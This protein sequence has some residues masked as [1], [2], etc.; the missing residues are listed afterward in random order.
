LIVDAASRAAMVVELLAEAYP[1]A[2]C[3][4]DHGSPWQ[5]LVATVLSAQCTDVRVNRV[6]PELFARWPGPAEM[7]AAS[8][9][10]LESVIRSTGMFRRKAASL[11]NAARLVVDRH[12]GEVPSTMDAL[13][14][15]PGVGRK[16]AKV[17]LGEGFGIA[18]GVTVDTHVRRLARRLGLTSLDDPEKIAA[19]LERLIRR[20][21]WI[22]FA[23][24]LI[25]HGRRVC[26]ARTPRCGDCVLEGL[27]PKIGVNQEDVTR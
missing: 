17:V 15:L 2:R 9:A 16:T 27:C 19:D 4:L 11:R 7:A 18:A 14:A 12:G 10:D 3:E 21:E 25:L 26:A 24:R 20:D 22:R 23:T 13:A 6:T 8:Q 1:E 5:L